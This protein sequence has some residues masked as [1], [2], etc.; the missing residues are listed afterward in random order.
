ME[1]TFIDID[2]E[3]SFDRIGCILLALTHLKSRN[4][5]LYT[6]LYVNI[7]H[8]ARLDNNTVFNFEGS[9]VLTR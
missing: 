5:N 4:S 3:I 9:L 8:F 7:R 1:I 2:L 6:V